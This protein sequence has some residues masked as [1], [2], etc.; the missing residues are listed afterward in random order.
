MRHLKSLVLLGVFIFGASYAHAQGPGYDPTYN[1]EYQGNPNPSYQDPN[2]S[3]PNYPDQQYSHP[4]DEN[5]NYDR[6]YEEQ[7]Y[8]APG[9]ATPGYATP[10]YAPHQ[11]A[12]TDTTHII[13]THVRRPVITYL[14]GS[15]AECSSVRDRGST[16][17]RFIG[18]AALLSLAT[19]PYFQDERPL[20][21]FTVM[22]FEE[23]RPVDAAF[24]VVEAGSTVAAPM[25]DADNTI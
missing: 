8:A 2:Y 14:R 23:H 7:G 10:A 17:V 16:A 6:S 3:A 11:H 24:I 15:R 22:H 25:V 9:Y 12:L 21:D 20:A 5:P 1:Q 18:E 4:S 19:V 13:R